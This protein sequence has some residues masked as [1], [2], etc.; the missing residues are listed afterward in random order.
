MT[1]QYIESE[2]EI[3]VTYPDAPNDDPVIWDRLES[4]CNFRWSET[5]MEFVVNPPCEIQ[6]QP[7][8]EPFLIMEVNGE[9]AEPD[10]YGAVKIRD[11]SIIRA[12]IGGA[13]PSAT[14][15]KAY[16]RLADYFAAENEAPAGVQR[17]SVTIGDI[18]ETYSMRS[19]HLSRAMQN[20]GAADLLR[21]YRKA[22][23]AHV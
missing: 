9:P 18:S 5:V 3:S 17:Y 6:W 13:V 23:I 19:D 1:S 20:S 16:Q 7:P 22:G 10:E 8:Y 11:K 2:T 21:K 15:L 4:F 14:V 12:T